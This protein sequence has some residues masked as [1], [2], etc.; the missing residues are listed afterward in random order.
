[1]SGVYIKDFAMYEVCNDPNG[2]WG[3]PLFRSQHPWFWCNATSFAII[4]PFA[5][6]PWCPLISVPDHGRLI[7]ADAFSAKIIEIIEARGYDDF[8][9]Q[10]LSTGEILR[11]VVHE[12]MGTGLDGYANAPTVIPEDKEG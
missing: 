11:Q 5:K 12:L 2:H 7:D 10:S 6:Q 3:C 4:D 1:M 8:Y 9:A